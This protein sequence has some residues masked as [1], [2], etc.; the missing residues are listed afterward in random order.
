MELSFG[1]LPFEPCHRPGHACLVVL[2]FLQPVGFSG[3]FPVVSAVCRISSGF[4]TC[5]VPVP[6]L[7]LH[8]QAFV[9][10]DAV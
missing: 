7:P 3:F 9:D 8:K 4:I 1:V 5:D 10:G 2:K 6:I